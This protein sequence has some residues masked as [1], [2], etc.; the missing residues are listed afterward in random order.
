MKLLW[1]IVLG[2]LIAAVMGASS[3]TKVSYVCDD[4][5]WAG[6]VQVS[7]NK[8]ERFTAELGFCSSGLVMWRVT[9][10]FK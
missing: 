9:P 6:T 3:T 5:L 8:G 7:P 2:L 1:G 10:Q 4:A